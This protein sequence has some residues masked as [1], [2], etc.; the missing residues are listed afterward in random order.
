[1]AKMSNLWG[2]TSLNTI[3]KS[4][5]DQQTQN[6]IITEDGIILCIQ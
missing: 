1:M 4:I 5:F 3:D 2:P 6:N